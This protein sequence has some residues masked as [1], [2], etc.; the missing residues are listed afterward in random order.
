MIRLYF[1]SWK[2]G[3][4]PWSLDEGP[5]TSEQT[6][7]IVQLRNVIGE[8]KSDPSKRGSKTEPAAWIE[9]IGGNVT[10]ID[11]PSSDDV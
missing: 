9:I 1:N 6:A 7:D 2:T 10:L 4:K 3:E 11:L 8:V 5:G